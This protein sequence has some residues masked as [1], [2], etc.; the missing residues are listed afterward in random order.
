VVFG[1]AAGSDAAEV[2][3]DVEVAQNHVAGI[4]KQR[5]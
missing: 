1:P 3:L 4:R 5:R 2:R